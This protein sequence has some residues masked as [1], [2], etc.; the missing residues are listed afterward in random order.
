MYT[1]F[2]KNINKRKE[3][4]IN[5]IEYILLKLRLE[6]N[7]EINLFLNLFYSSLVII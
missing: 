3:M 4:I 2:K 1:T 6:H 7:I 5:I